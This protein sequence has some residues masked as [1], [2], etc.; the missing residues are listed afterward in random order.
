M[1]ATVGHSAPAAPDGSEFGIFATVKNEGGR[2][3]VLDL[4]PHP[5]LAAG[6]AVEPAMNVP[7]M[8]TTVPA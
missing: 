5:A 2:F 8:I 6:G 3:R 4:I 7:V 1:A